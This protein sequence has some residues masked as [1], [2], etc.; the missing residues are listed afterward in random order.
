MKRQRRLL[1][2]L[3]VPVLLVGAVAV[4]FRILLPAER[5][6]AIVAS[7]AEAALGREVTIERVTIRLI[8][9]PAVS[10]ER[11]AV[12]GRQPDDPPLATVR[13]LRLQ[14]RI[15]PLFKRQVIIDAVTLDSPRLL[16]ESDAERVS[17]L[18]ILDTA[19]GERSLGDVTF[20][21]RSLRIRDGR[22]AYR[23]RVSG[24]VIRLDGIEQELRIAGRMHAGELAALELDGEL[25][26]AS[27][28]AVLPEHL[29]TPI[30]DVRLRVEHRALL[31]LAADSIA[32]ERLSVR[33]Q[34]VTL[35]G[36][37]TL[38]NVS[39]PERRAISMRL[40]AAAIQ[41]EPL[42]KSVPRDLVE[43]AG[44]LPDVRGEAAFRILAEGPLRPDSL[45]RIDGTLTLQRFDVDYADVPGVLQGVGGVI[46]FSLDSVTTSGLRGQLLG[47][48]FELDLSIHDLAAPVARAALHA[49]VPVDR[50]LRLAAAPDSL[51]AGG[52]LGV[53]LAVRAPILEPELAEV[54]G[55]LRLQGLSVTSPPLLETLAVET[56]ALTFLGRDVRVDDLV[57][58]AGASDVTLSANVRD[59]PALVF[60]DAG[61][62]ASADFDARSATL[63]LDAILGVPDSAL[64]STLLFARLADDRI[65]GRPVAEIAAEAG[66][67]LPPLPPIELDGRLRA[68]RFRRNGL[69]LQDV[70]ARL[71]GRGDRLEL[72]DASFEFLGGGVKI[73][74]Q[75]GLP[76]PAPAAAD[77]STDEAGIGYPTVLTYQLQ[78]IGAAA[79]FDRFTPFKEH[80][81]GSLLLAGTVQLV[82]DEH[83]LPFRESVVAE[84][85]IAIRNGRIVNWPVLQE[86]GERLGLAATFDT[87]DFRDWAGEFHIAG[88]R[89]SLGQ[90]AIESG[91]LHVRAVGAFDFSGDLDLTA[92]LGLS[93]DLADRVSGTFASRLANAVKGEDGRVPIGVRVTG[94]ALKPELEI[95]ASEAA[96]NAVDRARGE[97]ESRARSL[98]ES[99]ARRA[100][101]R[102]GIG[103]AG[104][105]PAAPDSAAV[106]DS[107]VADSLAP[108]PADSSATDPTPAERAGAIVEAADS[109]TRSAA[110]SAR[111]RIQNEVRRRLCVLRSCD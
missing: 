80:L 98:A 18:P 92:T 59:W 58:R 88:P 42:I 106:P 82:L 110:D 15:L 111:S 2:F 5:I 36:V 90:T 4:A 78:D 108:S 38:H 33:L 37:A 47:H 75:V 68:W 64:Y 76:R 43:R 40:G 61:R 27:L 87:L 104:G 26:A 89:I 94:R 3:L 74:G 85:S 1:L 6:G 95:D 72:T 86:L 105:D 99:A 25:D 57:L 54:E 34:E 11:V 22:I 60:E 69:E 53:D 66:L 41:A 62:T 109:V 12:A 21:V 63:D 16:A 97:V 31:D 102:L 7:H 29:A 70:D 100:A 13:R 103:R 52:V 51:R 20:L 17:E 84:G 32:V 28:G 44:R 96:A 81:S 46:A 19:T 93:A 50:A 30:Q 24:R 45:P 14:P 101:E 56:G 49:S 65:D 35:E 8:P 48:P 39:D 77:D 55:T 67:G 9:A 71:R 79:F 107:A 73:A 23:D 91:D 10:L 83:L